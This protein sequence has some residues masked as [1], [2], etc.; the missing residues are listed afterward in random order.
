MW[1]NIYLGI[2]YELGVREGGDGEQEAV[3]SE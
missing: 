2:S 3:N 1:D